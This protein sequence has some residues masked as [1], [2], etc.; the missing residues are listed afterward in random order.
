MDDVYNF[1][2]ITAAG[3]YVLSANPGVLQNL[4]I[5]KASAQTITLYDGPAA[6]GTVIATLPA[7]ANAGTYFY[8]VMCSTNITVVAAAS[9]GGDCTIIYTPTGATS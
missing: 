8:Q 6:T 5:N 4:V 7:S 3:T 2:N 9:Y 1:L